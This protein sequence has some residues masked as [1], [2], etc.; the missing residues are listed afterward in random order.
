MMELNFTLAM[1]IKTPQKKDL[2]LTF[3]Q[4]VVTEIIKKIALK[5]LNGYIWKKIS[6]TILKLG[7]MSTH[8]LII[9]Q[10][11]S[12]LSSQRSL[13]TNILSRNYKN[14]HWH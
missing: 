9:L 5:Y 8:I 12:R 14:L 6:C 13:I 2:L 10:F 4:Q 3:I 11:Q 1:F 7:I